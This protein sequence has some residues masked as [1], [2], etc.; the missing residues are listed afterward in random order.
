MVRQ[1]N[2]QRKKDNDLQ[3]TI[4]K[5]KDQATW[6]PLKTGGELMWNGQVGSPCSI[7]DIRHVSIVTD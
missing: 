2:D 7:C 3:N 5:T 6:T 4:Q 1:H